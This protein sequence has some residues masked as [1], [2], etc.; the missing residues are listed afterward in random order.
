M[1][2]SKYISIFASGKYNIG[3]DV[4]YIKRCVFHVFT[5]VCLFYD[6]RSTRGVLSDTLFNCIGI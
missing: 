6:K 3:N 5:I 2:S 1:R 4:R